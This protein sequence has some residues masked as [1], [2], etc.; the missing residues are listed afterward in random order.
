MKSLR[1]LDR[2]AGYSLAS[3]GMLLGVVVPSVIPAFASAATLTTRSIAMSSSVAA[4]TGADYSVTFTPSGASWQHAV[5]DWCLDSPVIGQNTCTDPV[6]FDAKTGVSISGGAI[7]TASINASS[8]R[9]HTIIDGTSASTSTSPTTF[10]LSGIHNPTAVGSF[11]ARIYTYA[12]V[13]YTDFDTLGTTVDTG[14]VALSTTDAVGVSAAVRETMTFCVSKSAPG[15]NCSGTDS[16][17]L[18]LGEGATDDLKALDSTHVSSG[19]NY[20]QISTNASSGAIVNLHN[21]TVGCGGLVRAGATNCDIKPSG[22]NS[23]G[24]LDSTGGLALFGV[25]LGTPSTLTDGSGTFQAAATSSYNASTYYMD[26]ATGDTTGVTSTYGSPFL[27]TDSLPI[28]NVNMPLTFGASVSNT[29]PAGLYKA[30]L[31][32]VATGKF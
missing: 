14:A 22:V 23:N 21:S 18:I 31:N 16:P 27:D 25:K 7:G 8:T 5:I 4:A 6:G 3:I 20:A 11:Y 15:V 12:T 28:N 29:T 1:F 26:Y 10:V 9:I 13:N 24:V 19:T 30:T 2:R 17:S 32:L